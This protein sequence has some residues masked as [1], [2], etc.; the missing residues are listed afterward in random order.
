MLAHLKIAVGT[1]LR[2]Q[3]SFFLSWKVDP[4]QGSG[5]VSLWMNPSQHVGFR[6]SGSRPPE[7]NK[8]WLWVLV[9]L[10][11]SHRGLIVVHEKEAE[12][13]VLEKAK[14]QREE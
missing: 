10:A 5:R 6:F 1:K 4:S 11:D 2:K 7:L 12:A 3:E 13:Y 9:E 8:T 14:S